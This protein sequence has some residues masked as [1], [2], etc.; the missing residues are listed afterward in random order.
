MF[1]GAEVFSEGEGAGEGHVA[2]E[3]FAVGPVLEVWGDLVWW[4]S[5]MTHRYA[6]HLNAIEKEEAHPLETTEAPASVLRQVVQ[7]K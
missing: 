3:I 2:E 5:W 4:K 7:Q 1:I 6:S